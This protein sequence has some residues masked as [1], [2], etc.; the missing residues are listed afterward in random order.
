LPNLRKDTKPGIL[1][2]CSGGTI[3]IDEVASLP[4]GAQIFLM[5]VLD[6][7]PMAR[8]TGTEHIDHIDV[9]FIFATN[10][11][12]E[13]AVQ[14]KRIRHDFFA[15]IKQNHIEIPALNERLDDIPLFVR[16]RLPNHQ[17]EDNFLLALLKFDWPG[18]VRQLVHV[19]RRIAGRVNNRKQ[20][21]AI[22]LLDGLGV[23]SVDSVRSIDAHESSRELLR[24]L[25]DRLEAQ[26]WRKGE[27]LQEQLA[28]V[29]GMSNSKVSKILSGQTTARRRQAP[30]A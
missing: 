27:G 20:K 10:E 7:R 25:K 4:M 30:G 9:R 15:R 3:F 16:Y 13:V 12:M 28:R 19:L 18:N 6:G 23:T 29:T 14:Q 11:D 5:Q 24:L 1:E 8:L 21:L 17:W 26:G 22:D 2:D